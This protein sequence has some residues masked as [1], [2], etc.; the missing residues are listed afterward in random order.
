MNRK[1][2]TL[3][4]LLFLFATNVSAQVTITDADLEGGQTYNWTADTEYI[5][6]GY[7]YLEP[8]GVLNI[9]PGTVIKGKEAPTVMGEVS[10]LIITRGAQIFAEGTAS[11]PIVFTTD[12][13]DGNLD[14]QD[15]GLWGGLVILGSAEIARPGGTDVIEGIPV[16][17][18]NRTEYGGGANPNNAESSGV[19]T[20]VSIRHGGAEL[21]PMN[22]INGL[23]LGGVGSGTSIDFIEVFANSDDGIE[24][25]GGTV[26]V[27]HAVVAF[28]GDDGMDYDFG[29]RGKGQFWFVI[30][31]EDEG[32]HAG[33]HDGANPDGQTPFSKPEIYN[34]TYIGSGVG[35]SNVDNDFVFLFRDNAGGTYANSIF[36]DFAE[37]AINVEDLDVGSTDP[38][39]RDRMLAGDLVLSNNFWFG[40][41]DGSNLNDLVATYPNGDD[42]TAQYVVD[43]LVN[44]AN[45]LTDPQ[46]AGISREPNMQLDPRLNAGSPALTLGT[47][48]PQDGFFDN[49]FYHGAFNNSTN[50]A[51]GWTAL[52]EKGYFGD[53]VTPVQGGVICV[54]DNDLLGGQTYN[55]T[56]DNTYCLDGYVY[57]ETGSTLN[58]EPGTVIYGKEVPS[59]AGE[60]STL[61]ITRG[62]T[63]NA[64]GT[65]T[66]PIIFTAESVWD[67]SI[68]GDVDVNGLWGGLVILG[69]AEIARPGGTDVIEGIPEDPQNRTEYGGG[70]N[71]DNTDNSGTLN[72]V[73]IRH[74]GAELAPM[75]EINGLTLGGVGSDTEIDF[76][77]VYA[78]S[79]D[80]IEWFGGTVNV[81]H[82]VVAFCGDDGMDYDFG[83]RG[84][85][86]YWFVIQREDEGNHAGEHDG[87]NPDGQAPFSKPEIYNATYI[88]SGVGASNTDNDFVFLFRDNAGGTYANSIFTDF[89][90][91]AI[92]VEDLDAGS[93]DPDSRDRVLAGDLVLKNN[94]WFGFGDGS[95]LADLVATYPNGDDPSAQYLIDH[96]VNNTNLL[97]DPEIA[98]IDRSAGSMMLDPRLDG[99]S[100]ALSAGDIPTDPFFDVTSYHG[101]FDN[102]NNWARS[103]T[104]L[105]EYGHFGD[106]VE[107][108]T[109]QTICIQD[110]D[111]LGG[112]TYNWT[113][114]NIYC[115]DGYVYL[116]AGGVLNIEAGTVIYGMESPTTSAGDVSTLIITKGAQIFAEGN[117]AEP[118]IFTAEGVVDGSIANPDEQDNGLWGGLVILGEAE[119]GRPGGTDVIEGIPADAQNRTEYGGGANPNNNDDS[120]SLKYISI[121]HGGAELAPM[122]EINGLTLGGVGSGTE[123]DYVEVFANS[124]DGIEWFG[125]TVNVKHAIVAFAGDDGMDYDYGWRGKGQYWFVIQ[126]EDA[127]NHAG[128]HDGAN[129]DGQNPF[130]NPEIY[131]ATYIGS[132]VG[133]SNVDNDFVFLFRDNAGGTYANSIFTEFAED[134]IN[135]EDLPAASTDPDSHDRLLAGDLQL[136]NNYWYQFGGGD[137]LSD[138]V[139]TYADGDDPDASD[140]V[141]HLVN[142]NN[143]FGNMEAQNPQICGISRVADGGLYPLLGPSSPAITGGITPTDAF[144][145][146]VT[147][148]GAFDQN[149]NWAANWTALEEYGYLASSCSVVST[150]DLFDENQGFILNQNTPNPAIDITTFEYTV[151]VSSDILIELYDLNGKRLKTLV[152]DDVYA[153]THTVDLSVSNFANGTYFVTL[154]SNQV[155]LVRKMTVV[156]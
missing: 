150:N 70:A 141:D 3:L 136:L 11:N 142:N 8:G 120:G 145:D 4:A 105:E 77:E 29:W 64:V 122:S 22:E 133:A 100:F 66:E 72:Y 30:Q 9:E 149:N 10:T 139:A 54:T 24:W 68:D 65:A 153:G 152:N 98:S 57:L 80:G 130:S 131:N 26:N 90:E 40:F 115:L 44:N 135:I 123:I 36:T 51:L 110:G 147:Y 119:I 15:N 37:K 89:A 43:H 1:F 92:N 31:R 39:S 69:N 102:T 93:T 75:N 151:P 127:G 25:F 19:L 14:E 140:V 71:P 82:A 95:D 62:A 38:D 148:H 107:P 2:Y 48:V 106:L 87:A 35:A 144:F 32:N 124:D 134:A 33:E 27:K 108:V 97:N 67:G 6:D 20:Y 155:V 84:K 56:N 118:I 47:T 12:G 128:E 143:I 5:L 55:W 146:N 63:I 78:N 88:G 103:W 126:R 52:S 85:G 76:V 86:Q 41:G 21:A 46:I 42:P 13:D 58:I 121:R 60:V 154:T 61:V 94:V 137:N 104:A 113:K 79:D 96:L 91:K 23:T 73:S 81:K 109:G 125:G 156:K 74:G 83:W 111:L 18:Q 59:N 49:V 112:Q 116:E 34:A 114:N 16:D 53:L 132:G 17:P 28:C 45:Q 129:P 50:W 138:V 7:V 99:T 117:P 101:A